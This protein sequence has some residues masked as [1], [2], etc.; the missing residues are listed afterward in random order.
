MKSILIAV[1]SLFLF[2]GVALAEEEGYVYHDYS[3]VYE[4]NLGD[5][6]SVI[7]VGSDNTSIYVPANDEKEV[8]PNQITFSGDMINIVLM[9]T[10]IYSE[11][12]QKYEKI[13]LRIPSE[14]AIEGLIHWEQ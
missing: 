2:F 4:F 10:E 1:L 3:N 8:V 13:I 9:K 12:I 7:V 5:G 11:G 14:V 6:N